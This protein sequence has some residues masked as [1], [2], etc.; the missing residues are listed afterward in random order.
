MMF[1]SYWTIFMRTYSV[2]DANRHFKEVLDR[3]KSG[4]TIVVTENGRA[5]AEVAPASA[6]LNTRFSSLERLQEVR[7]LFKGVTLND[8]ISARHEGHKY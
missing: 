3:V 6:G 4:E 5:V 7:R 1:A 2:S 8:M